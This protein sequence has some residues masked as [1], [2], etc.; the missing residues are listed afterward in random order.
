MQEATK[1]VGND[2]ESSSPRLVFRSCRRRYMPSSLG[3]CLF[4]EPD[5]GNLPVRFDEREQ[6]TGLSQTELRRRG[7]NR[8]TYPPG[9]YRHCAGSRLYSPAPLPVPEVVEYPAGISR[10]LKTGGDI[11][12]SVDLS[13]DR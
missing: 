11:D 5:A 4:R 8:V 2:D 7:E 1:D 10:R 3:V 12:E 9:D 13:R 6:E